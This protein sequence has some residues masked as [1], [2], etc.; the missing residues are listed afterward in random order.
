MNYV[1][2]NP[3]YHTPLDGILASIVYLSIKQA[4][5]NC[6]LE[7]Y[8][9]DEVK[10]PTYQENIVFLLLW[11]CEFFFYY[12]FERMTFTFLKIVATMAAR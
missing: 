7:K 3:T 4:T 9:G 12:P 6:F 1:D 10:K 5:F 2:V 11:L 8:I